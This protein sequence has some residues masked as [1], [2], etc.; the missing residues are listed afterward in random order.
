MLKKFAKIIIQ[1]MT[2]RQL[3]YSYLSNFHHQ[4][5]DFFNTGLLRHSTAAKEQTSPEEVTWLVME[6]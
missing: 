6:I 1:L 2:L 3:K 4:P 5:G